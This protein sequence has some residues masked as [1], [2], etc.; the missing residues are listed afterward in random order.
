[1]TELVLWTVA[2]KLTLSGICL[3]LLSDR[4]KLRQLALCFASHERHQLPI[5]G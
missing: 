1:M 3:T 2:R 4:D 5:L